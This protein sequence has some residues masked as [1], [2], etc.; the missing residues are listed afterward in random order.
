MR[1]AVLAVVVLLLPGVSGSALAQRFIIIPDHGSGDKIVVLCELPPNARAAVKEKLH[2]EPRVGFLYW[3]CYVF[4]N[5]F[6]LWTSNGRFVLFDADTYW[7]VPREALA[8]MLGP[9]ASKLTVPWS[10]RIPPGLATTVGIVVAIVIIW[11]LSARSRANRL[12]KDDR[13][14]EALQVYGKGLP[15]E[16]EPTREQKQKSLASAVEFLQ[17]YGIP[18]AT[19][20]E[21]LRLLIGELDRDRSNELRGFAVD[22]EQS[23]EWEQAILLYEQA[24]RLREDW[25]PKDHQFLLK[26][27]ERV[28]SKQARAPRG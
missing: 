4:G 13:Y 24:A 2:A 5:E 19:G 7:D 11:Y 20:E 14:Q 27:I 8:D 9:D 1:L 3:H 6:A 16:G 10:Y 21:R 23:G 15:A 12:L 18:A 17:N 26:C 22:F 28:R 25:D